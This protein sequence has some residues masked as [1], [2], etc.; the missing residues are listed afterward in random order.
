MMAITK[1]HVKVCALL[2]R[3]GASVDHKNSVC[4]VYYNIL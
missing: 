4:D 2:L 1:G 3:K